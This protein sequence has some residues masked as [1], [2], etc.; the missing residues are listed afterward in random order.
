MVHFSLHV[1]NISPVSAFG[2]WVGS[3]SVK[4]ITDPRRC[5]AFIK[6]LFRSV[7]ER[8]IY[9]AVD[10]LDTT[11]RITDPNVIGYEH[12]DVARG[13]QKLLHDYKSLQDI[14]A[15]LGTDELSEEDKLKV[16]RARKINEIPLP[17]FPGII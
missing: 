14:I 15:F 8:R 3:G 11:S 16:A 2:F 9:P 17:A 4:K 10:P 7:A 6:Y 12:Y 13:V 5:L 1:C